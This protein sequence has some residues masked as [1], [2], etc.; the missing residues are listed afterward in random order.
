M[1]VLA[2]CGLRQSG[3]AFRRFAS[4]ASA[5]ALASHIKRELEA[6]KA[7]GTFKQE[8]IIASRQAAL[9]NT[10]PSLK[11]EPVQVLNMC[12]NNYLGWCNNS[13]MFSPGFFAIITQEFARHNGCCQK[14]HRCQGCRPFIC[15]LYLWHSGR[16]LLG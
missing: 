13:G 7:E 14:G 3:H 10:K 2:S 9:V 11:E 4:S 1:H 8:K 12:S 15:S 6:M 16:S 5:Q